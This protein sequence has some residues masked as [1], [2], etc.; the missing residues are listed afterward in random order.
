[1]LAPFDSIKPIPLAAKLYCRNALLQTD[2]V[3]KNIMLEKGDDGPYVAKRP[4]LR[5][6]MNLTGLGIGTNFQGM[7]AIGAGTTSDSDVLV[8]C[9]DYLVSLNKILQGLGAGAL[10][11]I[12]LTGGVGTQVAS[13]LYQCANVVTSSSVYIILQ[14]SQFIFLWGYLGAGVWSKLGTSASQPLVPS[15]CELD[16]T[17][18]IMD[19]GGKIWASELNNPTSWPV[20]NYVPL[21]DAVGSPV[22]LAVHLNYLVAF[23]T[24]S[25]TMYYDAA[26]SPG[27][28]IAKVTSAI[29]TEGISSYGS[30]TVQE[31]DDVMYWLGG[32]SVTGFVINRMRGL[33][34]EKIS[35]PTIERLL[36]KYFLPAD[37]DAHTLS[38][39]TYPSSPRAYTVRAAGHSFYILSSPAYTDIYGTAKPGLTLSFDTDNGEWHWWTQVSDTNVEA[40]WGI[41]GAL[42]M[43]SY[44]TVAMPHLST[45]QIYTLDGDYYRDGYKPI[46]V[47]VQTPSINFGNQR[48]KL[49]P[50]TY[51]HADTSSTSVDISWSDDDYATFCTPITLS[52]ATPK[53]QLIRCGSMTERAWRVTHT[54]NAPLYLYNMLPE[55]QPGA[56]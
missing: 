31:M 12:P 41:G 4:G 27:A 23:C 53:K 13:S 51:L 47:Q 33:T 28:P 38:Q 10:S 7:S 6:T 22:R 15:I 37:A 54:D 32:S 42:P 50:A 26:I 36:A 56:L 40:E 24:D 39:I 44:G 9:G 49:I 30:R 25:I 46:N 3:C 52:L 17:F 1:M 16:G 29:F 45:G 43:R 55:L 48:T 18:Y 5:P 21:G 2:S 34:I 19:K 8:I 35:T 14:S 11:A 20:L